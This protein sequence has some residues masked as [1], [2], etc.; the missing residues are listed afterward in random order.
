MYH[1]IHLDE[2]LY[3]KTFYIEHYQI[4]WC[5]SSVWTIRWHL[6]AKPRWSFYFLYFLYTSECWE[7]RLLLF[8]FWKVLSVWWE[9]KKSRSKWQVVKMASA[10]IFVSW[11]SWFMFI[12]QMSS[13][14]FVQQNFFFDQLTVQLVSLNMPVLSHLV[15]RIYFRDQMTLHICKYGQ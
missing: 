14:I 12:I 7:K 5:P 15:P 3:Q 8:F 10:H 9:N 1:C 13:H 2:R 4:R 6:K 11:L